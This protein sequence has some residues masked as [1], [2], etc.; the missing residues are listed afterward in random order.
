M[1]CFLNFYCNYLILVTN[2]LYLMT[3]NGLKLFGKI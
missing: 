3:S 2:N 1:S